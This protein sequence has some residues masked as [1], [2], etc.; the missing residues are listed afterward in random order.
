MQTEKIER[1]LE[2]EQQ[3]VLIVSHRNPD[4]DAMGASFALY[5]YLKKMGHNVNM[6]VPN[7]YPQNLNWIKNVKNTLIFEWH[8][9]KCKHV[10]KEHSILFAVDFNDLYRVEEFSTFINDS[11]SYKVLIDHHPNPGNFADLIISET[12][13]SSASELTYLFLKK[14]DRKKLIDKDIAECIFAGIM[15]DTGCFS[16]NS[17]NRQ[18]YE[19]VAE[20]L[21]YG[22]DK[23]KIYGL[24]FDNY[25]V[26][27][28]RLM[29]HILFNNMVVLPEY[30][31][32]YISLSQSDMKKFNF[33]VGDS[34]GFVNM[35]LSIKGI[36]FSVLFTEKE[37]VVRVS[38]R[39]KGNFD[40]NKIAMKYFDGGGHK[41][42]SGGE[43]KLKLDKTI[44]KFVSIL[45]EI[46]DNLLND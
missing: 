2:T 23:D 5:N 41:N 25:S 22:I 11:D 10:F 17:S 26:D 39:S 16:F 7:A 31:T 15:M 8:K 36:K 45:P 21:E 43:S 35:P 24:V 29:G 27:R 28:L 3:N 12:Y 33:R 40:V 38:L 46:E 20:L 9:S 13:V 30:N 6:V 18:T 4:G 34:E 42:A 37:D 19:V 44:E 1:L 32:A 14:M